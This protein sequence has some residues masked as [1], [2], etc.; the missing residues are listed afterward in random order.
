MALGAAVSFLANKV[1]NFRFE[2]ADYPV[3]EDEYM[4]PVPSGDDD[5]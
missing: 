4:T 3:D 2:L 1:S 5:L